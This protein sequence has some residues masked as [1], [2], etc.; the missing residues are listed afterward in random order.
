M[1]SYGS[2]NNNNNGRD[3]ERTDRN[4]TGTGNDQFDTTFAGRS[5]YNQP[6][7]FGS[8]NTTDTGAG[9]ESSRRFDDNSNS[10]MGM[11]TGTGAGIGDSTY[12]SSTTG[13][14]DSY[15]STGTG[16]G[17]NDGFNDTS[18]RTDFDGGR[19]TGMGGKPTMGDKLKGGA[20]KLAGKVTNNPG[21]Q[22]RGQ[23]RKMGEFER[24]DY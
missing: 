19:T 6:D 3:F 18:N 17:M 11:G 5:G 20:E 7:Q 2:N 15:G 14:G 1:D 21:M 12:S 9:F 23:E 22:E 4:F 16:T 24:N 10:G 13:M 8:S